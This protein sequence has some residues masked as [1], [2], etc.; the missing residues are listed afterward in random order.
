MKHTSFSK[1]KIL[2]LV[3]VVLGVL[4]VG[5]FLLLS[6]GSDESE[7]PVTQY[8]DEQITETQ[9][10]HP[11]DGLLTVKKYHRLDGSLERSDVYLSNGKLRYREHYRA[12]GTLERSEGYHANG[13]LEYTEYFAADGETLV[14]VKH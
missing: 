2:Y 3:S 4:V 10:Q 14:D 1:N 8:S 9:E 12:D 6:Q 11:R 13:K 5:V 7:L